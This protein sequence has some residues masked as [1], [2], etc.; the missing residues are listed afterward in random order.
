MR[1]A[2]RGGTRRR[3]RARGSSARA[4]APATRAGRPRDR[5]RRGRRRRR[6][7]SGARARASSISAQRR[8]Q[9]GP[10]RARD[11]RVP[12][13]A[14]ERAA[15]A[16]PRPASPS[17]VRSA[18][19]SLGHLTPPRQLAG[20]QP[21]TAR[22]TCSQAPLDQLAPSARCS[23][24]RPSTCAETISGSVRV[25]AP[26]ADAHAH[27]VRAAELALERL[28][29]VVAREAT[30]EAGAHLAEGQV[31]LVVNHEH[32][33]ERQL[34]RSRAPGPPSD[35]RRSCRSADTAPPHAAGAGRAGLGA[36]AVRAR[37][38]GDAPA[39]AVLRAS[40]PPAL[41]E[42]LGDHEADVVPGARV[43]AAGVAQ[44]DDQPVDGSATP[45]DERGRRRGRA[46]LLAGGVLAPR[47][48]PSPRR[49]RRS[50]RR[51]LADELGLGLDFS[52]RSASRPAGAA[53]RASR[54]LS[55]RGRPAASRPRALRSR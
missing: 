53:A 54:R 42:R 24:K 32:P 26:D 50:P 52:L 1:R 36:P 45:P 3:R 20:P 7:A 29:P 6:P 21:S 43:L 4:A 8:D 33:L 15:P 49:P 11:E 41:D 28:Q 2:A 16:R 44:P 25:R 30:A 34:E 31:D 19:P 9:V 46:L 17:S 12:A 22:S 18:A 39:E 27:E 23:R 37:P 10:Q 48:A 38:F 55:P 47:A 35:R 40:K 5:A 13:L 51:A 14:R